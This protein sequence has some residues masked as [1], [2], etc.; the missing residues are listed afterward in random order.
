MSWLKKSKNKSASKSVPA[1]FYSD[2]EFNDY[3]LSHSKFVLGGKIKIENT[4]SLNKQ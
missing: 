1:Y 3:F 4:L 2:M